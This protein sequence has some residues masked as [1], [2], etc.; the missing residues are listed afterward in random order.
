MISEDRVIVSFLKKP[1]EAVRAS[2]NRIW[3]RSVSALAG[4]VLAAGVIGLC[5]LAIFFGLLTY[6][7]ALLVY[8][9]ARGCARLVRWVQ[10][11]LSH[12]LVG[13]ACQ[14]GHRGE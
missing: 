13:R 3:G 10:H 5:T 11:T 1:S 4:Q 14:A 2:P 12:A 9:L 8:V 7:I 6:A